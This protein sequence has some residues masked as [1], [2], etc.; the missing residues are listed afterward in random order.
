M[1]TMDLISSTSKP[2]LAEVET[3]R[4]DEKSTE[5]F[6]NAQQRRLLWRTDLRILPMLAIVYSVSVIDRINIGSARVLGM[7]QDLGLDVG[8]RYSVILLLF[9]PAYALAD[10]PS[11]ILLVRLTPK[12]W[13]SFL[14]I[15]WGAVLTGMAFT[16][17][18]KVMVFLRFL[19]GLFEGGVL[20]AMVYIIGSWYVPQMIKKNIVY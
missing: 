20:P 17:N 11:N 4:V 9:F 6:T 3:T 19:L 12:Y 1:N 7:S 2:E 5:V 14:M 8:N 15:S 13:L 16:N 18:W 10:I